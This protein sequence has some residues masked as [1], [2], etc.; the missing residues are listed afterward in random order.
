MKTNSLPRRKR[1]IQGKD[2]S[3][4]IPERNNGIKEIIKETKQEIQDENS[5]AMNAKIVVEEEKREVKTTKT[6]TTFGINTDRREQL[7]KYKEERRRQRQQGT[8]TVTFIGASSKNETVEVP[9]FEETKEDIPVETKEEIKE[10]VIDVEIIEEEKEIMNI[11]GIYNEDNSAMEIPSLLG[12]QDSS[13]DEDDEYV[14]RFADYFNDNS[15]IEIPSLMNLMET[16]DE[17][18]NDDGNIDVI[19]YDNGSDKSSNYYNSNDDISKPDEDVDDIDEED[20]ADED[21]EEIEEENYVPEEEIQEED[22]S[23][24]QTILDELDM[25]YQTRDGSWLRFNNRMLLLAKDESVPLVERFKFLAITASNLDE[26]TCVR[27]SKLYKKIQSHNI[28]INGLLPR[29]LYYELRKEINKML[30]EQNRTLKLLLEKLKTE[31]DFELVNSKTELTKEEEKFCYKYFNKRLRSMLTPMISDCTHPFPKLKSKN[32]YL[33]AI[34]EDENGKMVFGTIPVPEQFNRIVQIRVSEDSPVTKFILLDELIK[35]YV[36]VL[37]NGMKLVHKCT[38]RI[39]RNMDYEMSIG[40]EFI[41][42]VMK[43]TLKNR[44]NGD[45]MRVE[46]YGNK[47]ESNIALRSELRYDKECV[48]YCDNVPDLS[49]CMAISELEFKPEIRKKLFYPKFAPSISPDVMNEDLFRRIDQE[50]I[51]LHH[52]YESYQT[53]VDFIKQAALDPDVLAIKQTLYRVSHDSPI[54]K[55]LMRAAEAGKQVTVILEVKARFDEANNLRWAAM[56]E[57]VGGHVI[58]GVDNLKTHCKMCMVV[59]RNHKEELEKYVHLCTGNYNEKNAK[60]YT[61][62]SL[63]TSRASITDDVEQLFNSLTGCSKPILNKIIASPYNLNE[64]L[65]EKIDTQINLAKQGK[66]ARIY[67]KVNGLTDKNIIDKLYDAA[68]NGVDVQLIVRSACGINDDSKIKV[69]SIVGRFLEHSRIFQF[70]YGK[71]EEVYIGSSDL[72][73]RNLYKRVEILVPLKGKAKEKVKSIME[74]FINDNSSNSF[75]IHNNRG[76]DDSTHSQSIFIK[77]AQEVSKVAEVA[78]RTVFKDKK[79]KKNK[80]KSSKKVIDMNVASQQNQSII[81]E[82]KPEFIK[83]E[84]PKQEERI[85]LKL[86]KRKIEEPKVTNVEVVE[87]AKTEVKNNKVVETKKNE[88]LKDH[89]NKTLI[90]GIWMTQ[91]EVEKLVEK[92]LAS[93]SWNL[94]ANYW[95]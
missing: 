14:N 12:I 74:V 67:M 1:N 94:G 27:L 87:E 70:G 4:Y 54:M 55:A 90:D 5:I 53:V 91:E 2:G 45:I 71:D 35:K 69:K 48:S 7:R 51:I 40:D 88:S 63:F 93:I 59:R 77:Q 43:T 58:Y 30:N 49:F 62:I 64:K 18:D 66:Q 57:R 83:K 10:E 38:Y 3:K 8:S 21:D 80:K 36:N 16:E 78:N 6:I 9:K 89:E 37:F 52:P 41:G 85:K 50:D 39:L 17:V 31:T 13:I 75:D 56:L 24:S 19:Q 79:K 33:G 81:E 32:L 60:I 68:N 28:C 61:D 73:E 26:F 65:I 22:E 42:D 29:Q 20:E 44:E 86:K 11:D 23:I 84:E 34:L 82:S 95:K 25:K 72:M 15:S 47:K 92:R 76:N 46:L